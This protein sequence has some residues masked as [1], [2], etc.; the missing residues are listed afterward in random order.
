MKSIIYS[1]VYSSPIFWL[2]GHI[3]NPLIFI[4][5]RSLPESPAKRYFSRIFDPNLIR[6]KI[7]IEFKRKM[8]T[9]KF[10][11]DMGTYLIDLNDH[12]G[13]QSFITRE[14]DSTVLKVA[15][16]LDLSSGDVL[17]DIGANTGLV[18][19]PFAKEFSAS[20]IGIE[21]SVS[22]ASI[23][24]R[25]V[26]LNNVNFKLHN[27]CAV[28]PELQKENKYISFYPKNGNSG[29]SSIYED[30]NKSR[31]SQSSEQVL[32]ST[33]DDLL[34]F[35]EIN[36][37]KLIKLDVEGAEEEVLKG[38]NSIREIDAPILFEFRIDLMSRDLDN[39]GSGFV[40]ILK[41]NF[42][43]FGLDFL[44]EGQV[45][46]IPFDVQQSTG[47]AIGLPLKNL[48][49]YKKIFLLNGF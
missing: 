1:L 13:Y 23:L 49:K 33:L 26:Q 47:M 36:S 22:N 4:I 21:A 30:W 25:N 39:D 45:N 42:V 12:I 7:S 20:V 15:R 24:K 32:I 18:S 11:G 27:I 43:L 46:L 48:E 31:I 41:A 5:L 6:K 10:S 14:F 29:A 44:D 34:D 37:I 19:I 17:L 2:T 16:C 9:C 35:S 8:I 28:G 3:R 38:F 40:S